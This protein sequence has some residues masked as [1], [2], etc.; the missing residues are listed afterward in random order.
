MQ[1]KIK[2]KAVAI[3]GASSEIDEATALM[4]AGQSAKLVLGARRSDL[5]NHS[6]N[7]FVKKLKRHPLSSGNHST[8]SWIMGRSIKIWCY[9]LVKTSSPHRALN[10]KP[11]GN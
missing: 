3:T 11:H 5:W 6:I 7:Y 4:P 8:N 10:E 1:N 9:L 2:G